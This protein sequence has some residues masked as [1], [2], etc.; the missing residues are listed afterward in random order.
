MNRRKTDKHAVTIDNSFPDAHSFMD[1]GTSMSGEEYLARKYCEPKPYW[2]CLH[3]LSGG[4]YYSYNEINFPEYWL[5]AVA[6]YIG[7]KP[8]TAAK[9]LHSRVE[10]G[11]AEFRAKKDRIYGNRNVLQRDG[12]ED[13]YRREDKAWDAFNAHKK[14]CLRAYLKAIATGKIE[15]QRARRR[16]RCEGEGCRELLSGRATFCDICKRAR[17]REAARAYRR[18]QHCGVISYTREISPKN[19]VFGSPDTPKTFHGNQ[20]LQTL[21]GRKEALTGD[22]GDKA[23]LVESR[24]AA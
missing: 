6:K 5:D 4:N 13:I 10:A 17:N 2:H 20:N 23:G 11:R 15:R 7:G 16:H 24:A 1:G 8:S 12:L 14:D 21:R 22:W 9:Q 18:N 19:R 3:D